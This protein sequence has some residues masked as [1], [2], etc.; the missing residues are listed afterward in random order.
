ME[1]LFYLL[2][3]PCQ[4]TF[5]YGSHIVD[6]IKRIPLYRQTHKYLSI[7]P[8]WRVKWDKKRIQECDEFIRNALKVHHT[9]VHNLDWVTGT[10]NDIYQTVENSLKSFGIVE[11]L[12]LLFNTN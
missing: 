9:N 4:N 10:P 5:C 1:G 6:G 11:L 12:P 7:G 8:V 2:S 3:D